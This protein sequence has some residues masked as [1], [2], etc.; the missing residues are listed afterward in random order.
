MQTAGGVVKCAW[1]AYCAVGDGVEI[2]ASREFT[3]AYIS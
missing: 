2:S 3:V 1:G